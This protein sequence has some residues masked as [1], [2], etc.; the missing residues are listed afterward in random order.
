MIHVGNRLHG[1]YTCTATP[2]AGRHRPGGRG[3]AGQ[4]FIHVTDLFRYL[5]VFILAALLLWLR[6]ALVGRE[7]AGSGVA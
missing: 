1:C 2:G 5:I 6:A 7:E 3:P 4:H